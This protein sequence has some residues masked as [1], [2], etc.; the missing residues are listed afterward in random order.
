MSQ[1]SSD[2]S[3]AARPGLLAHFGQSATYT[4]KGGSASSIT[5]MLELLDEEED[6][7]GQ[8]SNESARLT[9]STADVSDPD[10]GDVVSIDGR[11]WTVSRIESIIGG[12]ATLIVLRPVATSRARPGYR[13]ERV[14]FRRA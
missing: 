10:K 9:V 2:F 5:A 8:A 13:T 14:I 7:D 1:F 4:P 11:S 12:L 6:S 3:T